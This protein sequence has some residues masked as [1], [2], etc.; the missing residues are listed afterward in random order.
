VF[1]A[2]VEY[3]SAGEP[4]V[5]GHRLAV[6]AID[7][8]RFVR[9][10]PEVTMGPPTL[11]SLELD[12]AF[13][14]MGGPSDGDAA[15]GARAPLYTVLTADDERAAIESLPEI[16][17]PT[18]AVATGTDGAGHW[19]TDGHSEAGKRGKTGDNAGRK[20]DGVHRAGTPH[21]GRFRGCEGWHARRDSNPQPADPKSAALS[22]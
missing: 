10:H 12:P 6:E 7:A 3:P 16:I 11:R 9:R 21:T 18:A 14:A 2:I 19:H 4:E 20:G 15:T 5:A 13:L 17:A 1:P 22:N 8:G